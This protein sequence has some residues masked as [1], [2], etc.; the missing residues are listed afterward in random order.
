MPP[1]ATNRVD[2][3]AVRR[4][5][6]S[7]SVDE[8]HDALMYAFRQAAEGVDPLGPEERFFVGVLL[9]WAEEAG[10]DEGLVGFLRGLLTRVE[11]SDAPE[12]L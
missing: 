9:G 5:V 1:L 11:T 12:K 2:E 7:R 3:D 8:D 10:E 6:S 4:L